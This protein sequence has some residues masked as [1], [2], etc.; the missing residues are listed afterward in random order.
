MTGESEGSMNRLDMQAEKPY[1]VMID[2]K[3]ANLAYH[4][5]EQRGRPNGSPEV[6][7]YR[8]AD[9][10]DRG[11]AGASVRAWLATT[12]AITAERSLSSTARDRTFEIANHDSKS[13]ELIGE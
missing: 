7:W 12:T 11:L 5:W 10:I 1:D 9:D 13:E 3:I 6:D 4:Y 2:K 8:A